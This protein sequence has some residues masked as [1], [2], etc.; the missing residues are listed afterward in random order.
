M[1][2]SI[3]LLGAALASMIAWRSDPAP[4]SFVFVTINTDVPHAEAGR[5]NAADASTAS[6]A[7]GSTRLRM[8]LS[9]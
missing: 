4:L 3:V 6:P 8:R 1:L 5:S 2:N 7:G 9:R